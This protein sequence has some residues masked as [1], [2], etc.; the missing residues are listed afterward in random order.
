MKR[1]APVGLTVRA[2][3]WLLLVLCCGSLACWAQ[4]GLG[5]DVEAPEVLQGYL[6][7]DGVTP[8]SY[9]LTTPEQLQAFVKT[10]PPHT[11][12]KVLPAPPNPDPFLKGFSV[13]F[14]QSVIAVAVGRNRIARHP[15]YLGT[16]QTADGGRQVL[17]SLPAPTPEAFPFGWGVYSAVVLPR[18]EGATSVVVRSEET[19]LRRDDN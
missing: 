19:R 6:I 7:L 18:V 12:Y 8:E 10:L 4:P 13:D 9:L 1:C 3:S 11:P 16:R 17:F 2:L 5:E 15:V 14:E